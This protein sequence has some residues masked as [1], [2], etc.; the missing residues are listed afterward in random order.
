MKQTRIKVAK[1]SGK[2]QKNA[3]KRLSNEIINKYKSEKIINSL[4][5]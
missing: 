3:D 4:I 1:S 2:C 5:L